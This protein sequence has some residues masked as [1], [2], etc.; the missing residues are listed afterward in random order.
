VKECQLGTS[1]ALPNNSIIRSEVH[2]YAEDNTNSKLKPDTIEDVVDAAKF[3]LGEKSTKGS[4]N[5][6]REYI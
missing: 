4:N 5:V 1:A 2:E 6:R 3:N